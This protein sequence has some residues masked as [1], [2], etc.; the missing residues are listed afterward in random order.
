MNLPKKEKFITEKEAVSKIYRFCS[1]QERNQLEVRVKLN[2]FGLNFHKVEEIIAHLIEENFVNEERYAKL[3][4][5]SKF[6]IKNWGK[7]KIEASLKQKEIS[8]NLIK[9]ALKE[10]PDEAYVKTLI[11]LVVKRNEEEK[12]KEFFQRKGKVA[13][14]LIGKGY[15]PELVWEIINNTLLK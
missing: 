8:P 12:G 1:Y 11:H 7:R 10:I 6:R 3:Y 4:A 13:Q 15:E 14:Y 5:G 2:A 9:I